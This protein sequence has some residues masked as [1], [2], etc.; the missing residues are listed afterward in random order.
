MY[1]TIALVV[2]ILLMVV[3]FSRYVLSQD[4]LF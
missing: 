4:D 2:T 3:A 1:P